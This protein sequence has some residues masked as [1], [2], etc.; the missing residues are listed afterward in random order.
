M[1]LGVGAK[2]F[3]EVAVVEGEVALM[4]VVVGR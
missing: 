2:S 1:I 3:S 4:K